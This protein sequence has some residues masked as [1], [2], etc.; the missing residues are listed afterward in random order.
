MLYNILIQV[1]LGR[2]NLALVVGFLL[3]HVGRRSLV[4]ARTNVEAVLMR[5]A[6]GH[7]VMLGGLAVRGGPRRILATI[8][9]QVKLQCVG[10]SHHGAG[11]RPAFLLGLSRN[12]VRG[13]MAR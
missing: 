9:V 2:G 4:E 1:Q 6:G 8:V 10:C 5:V 3:V 13:S 11:W 7:L 12:E